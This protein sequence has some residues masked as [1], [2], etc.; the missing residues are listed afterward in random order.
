MFKETSLCTMFEIVIDLELTCILSVGVPGA[1]ALCG[2]L[3][4][5]LLYLYL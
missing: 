2:V 5:L 4:E 3:G 1:D